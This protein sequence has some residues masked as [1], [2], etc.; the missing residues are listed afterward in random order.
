[1]VRDL[2]TN[3]RHLILFLVVQ[4]IIISMI[5]M[6]HSLH[7]YNWKKKT[8]C[9]SQN[10]SEKKFQ[11]QQDI[12]RLLLIHKSR[13]VFSEGTETASFYLIWA[14]YHEKSFS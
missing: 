7:C 13:P 8:E 6:D 10:G 4:K 11:L 12:N 9:I 14:R 2:M 3:C 1:M 5:E